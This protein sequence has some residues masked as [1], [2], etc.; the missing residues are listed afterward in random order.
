M[1][2][3]K[4]KFLDEIEGYGDYGD[5]VIFEDGSIY[6]FKTDKWLSKRHD[7]DGYI[8]YHLYDGSGGG[9]FA[10]AHVLVAKAFIP[11]PDNSPTV[12][13][14]NR[15]KDDN[16]VDNLRWATHKTQNENRVPSK[17]REI[18]RVRDKTTGI[19][20]NNCADA[21]RG[22]EGNQRGVWRCCNSIFNTYKGHV[23]EYFE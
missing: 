18:K 10:R 2:E 11:N 15:V 7:K 19:L 8:E 16:L 17:V 1:R 6:S 23:F 22:I 20:Y 21:A 5:Y 4:W 9:C 14:I 12:D 3:L 13:H